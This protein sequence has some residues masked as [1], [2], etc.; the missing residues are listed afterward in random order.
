MHQVGF[1]ALQ[2]TEIDYSSRIILGGHEIA[3]GDGGP[4]KALPAGTERKTYKGWEEYIVPAIKTAPLKDNE[5][6]VDITEME[7]WAQA[8][9][10]GYKTLN[11]IQ[12]RIYQVR[13]VAWLRLAKGKGSGN[14]CRGNFVWRPRHKLCLMNTCLLLVIN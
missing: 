4:K 13:S 10:V 11:R 6:L 14:V 12:S 7:T 9:F 8:A 2:D 5:K 1:A 3:L